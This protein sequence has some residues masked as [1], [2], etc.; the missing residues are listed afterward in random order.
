MKH[1]FLSHAPADGVRAAAVVEALKARRWSVFR[2]DDAPSGRNLDELVNA[3][4]ATARCVV[5]LWSRTSASNDAVHH[6]ASVAKYRHVLVPVTIDRDLTIDDIPARFRDVQAEPLLGLANPRAA[7]FEPLV[8]TVARILSA[9][10]PVGRFLF[11]GAAAVALLLLGLVVARCV[12][13]LGNAARADLE[14]IEY[15]GFGGDEDARLVAA[16]RG[17]RTMKLLIPNGNRFIERFHADLQAFLAKPGTT[18]QVMLATANSP[19]YEQMTE[20]TFNTGWKEHDQG[21]AL[22]GNILRVAS[23]R[24]ALSELAGRDRDRVQFKYF[25][26]QFRAPIILIDN[27]FCFLTLRLPP[28]ESAQSLRLEFVGGDGGYVASCARHFDTLWGLAKD[29]APPG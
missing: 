12:S 1:V 16:I 14:H 28:D 5:V 17:A 10:R 24:A 29:P 20:M 7:D 15:R 23:S 8:A 3:E 11:G 19:F 18:M 26:T 2:R 9:Q 21:A 25:N 13:V 22:R 6:E 27:R 4:L